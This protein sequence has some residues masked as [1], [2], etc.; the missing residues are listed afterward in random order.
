MEGSHS[1]SL[2]VV[3]SVAYDSVRTPHG[4]REGVLGG[5]ATYFSLAASLFAPVGIVAVVGDDF[6]DEDLALLKAHGVAVD[7]LEQVSG[8]TFRWFGEYSQD[9]NSCRTLDT[10]LNVFAH[11]KPQLSEESRRAPL[12]FLANIDPDLQYQVLQQ[13]QNRPELVAADTMN[14]WIEGKRGALDRVMASVDALLIN[15]GEARLI[16]GESQTL[17]AARSIVGRGLHTL[18][19][20][21]G[22]YGALSFEPDSLFMAPAYPVEQVVDPTGAGDS[23]AGGFM[24]YLAAIEERSSKELRRAAVVGSV[25]ASFAVESFGP[26]RLA[27]VRP[28]EIQE[29]LQ[30]L[31]SFVGWEGLGEG[32]LPLREKD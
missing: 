21:R 9:M 4:S 13:M 7:G 31:E 20:K 19:V 2:L 3:G 18:V 26:Y 23:F 24:G 8:R 32:P 28:R 6:A 14:F 1:I 30:A 5:S 29:R 10:Q 22:E 11:F 25:M 15:E 16:A 27:Q 12:L 17:K